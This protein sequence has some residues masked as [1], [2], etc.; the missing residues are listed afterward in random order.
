MEALAGGSPS[1]GEGVSMTDDPD[2]LLGLMSAL[3]HQIMMV[4]RRMQED[5]LLIRGLTGRYEELEKRWLKAN[6]QL[7]G[8]DG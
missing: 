5:K 3:Q 7:K 4:R 8:K 6:R 1:Q 2:Q